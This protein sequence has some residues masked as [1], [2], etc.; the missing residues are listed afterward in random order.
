MADFLEHPGLKERNKMLVE[1]FAALAHLPHQRQLEVLAAWIPMDS[2][3][4]CHQLNVVEK[5]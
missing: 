4:D 3:R 2:L 5:R 1:L